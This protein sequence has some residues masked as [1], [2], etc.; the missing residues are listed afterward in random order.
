MDDN[1]TSLVGKTVLLTECGSEVGQAIAN[2]LSDFGVRL[3]VADQDRESVNKI[4]SQIENKGG[5]AVGYSFNP[6][7]EKVV[8]SILNQ[9]Y[10]QWGAINILVNNFGFNSRDTD[11]EHKR[12]GVYQQFLFCN[13]IFPLM[14]KS[15]GGQIV[16]IAPTPTVS[17]RSKDK[18][19][20]PRNGIVAFSNHLYNA[21][22]RYEIRVTALIAGGVKVP[23]IEQNFPGLDE[24]ATQDAQNLTEAVIFILTMPTESIVPEVMVLPLQDA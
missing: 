13:A 18:R 20:S 6:Q 5:F 24:F 22:K 21:G 19:V 9:I 12:T 15:G 23:F 14:K 7:N 3:I 8:K 2:L 1:F 4:V 16:N 17:Q 10:S 11:D